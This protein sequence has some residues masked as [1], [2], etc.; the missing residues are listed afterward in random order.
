MRPGIKMTY[1]QYL[2]EVF[3]FKNFHNAEKRARRL[4]T[5]CLGGANEGNSLIFDLPKSCCTI[6][7]SGT[8]NICKEIRW[9]KNWKT[10]GTPKLSKKTI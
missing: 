8:S 3:E 9:K 5:L 2:L 4:Q 1:L 7:T 10:L 6:R